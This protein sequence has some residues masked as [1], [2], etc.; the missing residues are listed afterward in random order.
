M[1]TVNSEHGNNSFRIRLVFVVDIVVPLF[2]C[3]S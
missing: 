3:T 1:V 2:I